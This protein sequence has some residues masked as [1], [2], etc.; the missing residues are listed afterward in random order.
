VGER[1]PPDVVRRTLESLRTEHSFACPFC[2]LGGAS[3]LPSG[4]GPLVEH[5]FGAGG[6]LRAALVQM[7]HRVYCPG[8]D[9]NFF[10]VYQ[11]LAPLPECPGCVSRVDVIAHPPK[12]IE[13]TPTFD[14]TA[15]CE[16]C[17][18][19]LGAITYEVCDVR[20]GG[21]VEGGT[22]P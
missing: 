15:R 5:S 6:E 1:V 11:P 8:E 7:T 3:L 22:D 18:E 10:L 20:D 13:P 17:L 9:R 19:E 16:L 21:I 14:A 4:E 2:N 12:Y